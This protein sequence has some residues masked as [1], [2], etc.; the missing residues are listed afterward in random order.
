MKYRYIYKICQYYDKINTVYAKYVK[1]I[2]PKKIAKRIKT[3]LLLN[4]PHPRLTAP[5]CVSG[6]NPPDLHHVDTWPY[7]ST[8]HS[9]SNIPYC[10]PNMDSVLAFGDLSTT[11]HLHSWMDLHHLWSS[12]PLH[13][14]LVFDPGCTLGLCCPWICIRPIISSQD[15][16]HH[17]EI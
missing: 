8:H 11:H 4:L 17:V 6:S 1:T 10:F 7:S 14:P 12:H 5:S 16:I 2:H 3:F 15:P 13:C 9:S